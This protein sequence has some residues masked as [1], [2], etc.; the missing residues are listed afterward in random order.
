MKRLILL[1]AV[2][3][4]TLTL[5]FGTG[6]WYRHKNPPIQGEMEDYATTNVLHEVVYARF[7]A[8]GDVSGLRDAIDTNLNS[9][10]ARVVQYR[11]SLDD[12]EFLRA[13]LY[14]LSSAARLWDEAPPFKSLEAESKNKSWWPEWQEMTARN[15]ELLD[16][17]KQQCAANPEFNCVS[18]NPSVKRDRLPVAP[19]LQ[20]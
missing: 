17:A 2:L 14:V 6:Y 15:I 1:V 19:Y 20:R 9:H 18:P 3:A 13:Q 4:I 8:K 12:E 16:W 5:G 10:L 11:G 7:L